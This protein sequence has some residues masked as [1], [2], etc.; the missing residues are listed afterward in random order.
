MTIVLF[1]HSVLRWTSLFLFWKQ[2]RHSYVTVLRHIVWGQWRHNDVTVTS[3][4]WGTASEDSDVTVTS[5]FSG[6]AP[7][8]KDVTVTSPFSNT[9]PKNSDVTVNGNVF[10]RCSWEQ[11]CHSK[12]HS[13]QAQHMRTLTSLCRRLS[14]LAGKLKATL[15]DWNVLNI[16]KFYITVLLFGKSIQEFNSG[17]LWFHV[18]TK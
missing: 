2:W 10:R 9:A 7:D 17:F 1:A 4:F 3:L 16:A 18:D 13:S 6:A 14:K 11:W 12:S 8:S 15:S 5:L